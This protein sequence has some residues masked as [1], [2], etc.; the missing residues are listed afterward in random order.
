M[1]NS[2]TSW[3]KFNRQDHLTYL[4]ISCLSQSIIQVLIMAYSLHMYC[5]LLLVLLSKQSEKK[6]T[7]VRYRGTSSS[8]SSHR[9]GE[10]QSIVSLSSSSSTNYENADEF[11]EARRNLIMCLYSVAD[12]RNAYASALSDNK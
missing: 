8:S 9:I 10:V 11:C 6:T 12:M 3:K 4:F 7:L 2:Y 5:S 1:V